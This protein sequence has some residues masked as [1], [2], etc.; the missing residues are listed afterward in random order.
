MHLTDTDIH[1]VCEELLE[2]H[3]QDGIVKVVSSLEGVQVAY[4]VDDKAEDPAYVYDEEAMGE[5][6]EARSRNG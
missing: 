3:G 1:N 4:Y 2:K 5:L 6:L